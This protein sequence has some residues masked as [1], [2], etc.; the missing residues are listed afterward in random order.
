MTETKGEIEKYLAEVDKEIQR[1]GNSARAAKIASE[2][3]KR[4]MLKG[5]DAVVKKRGLDE[6]LGSFAQ[7]A[8]EAA[9]KDAVETLADSLVKNDKYRVIVKTS[10]SPEKIRKTLGVFGNGVTIGD[11]IDG[12]SGDYV[13][14]LIPKNNLVGDEIFDVVENG[15]IPESLLGM[16]ILPPQL[17]RAVGT[18]DGEATDSLWGMQRLGADKYQAA[19][20]KATKV[21]VAVLDTGVDSS[22][23]DIKPVFDATLSKDF[24]KSG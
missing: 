15:K 16:E 17:V 22:H 1:S 3:K 2:A 8:D 5:I 13:E 9:L 14:I 6:Y 12:A 19:L 7:D 11:I 10:S 18:L 24:S 20:A 4:V 23:P 21:K